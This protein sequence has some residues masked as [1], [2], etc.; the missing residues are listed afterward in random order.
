MFRFLGGLATRHPAF[1]CLGW[2]LAGVAPV[3][4]FLTFVVIFLSVGGEVTSKSEAIAKDLK[5][6]GDK[7]PA[8]TKTDLDARI[9]AVRD[10]LAGTDVAAVKTA[11]DALTQASH[12]M[13]EEAYKAA[14]PTG[15]G[16]PPGEGGAG[17]P[18]GDPSAGA[19]PTGKKDDVVDAEFEEQK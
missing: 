9:K 3:L 1:I 15:A 6:L 13:A 4:T 19:A 10:A 14:G 17:G 5:D 16:G 12:K 8:E 18:A 7:I 11:A 2:I